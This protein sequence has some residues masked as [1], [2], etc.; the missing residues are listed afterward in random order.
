MII[1]TL[2]LIHSLIWQLIPSSLTG[3][4]LN[5]QKTH[6]AA[7]LYLLTISF[8]TL[9]FAVFLIVFRN[10]IGEFL[11]GDKTQDKEYKYDFN[12][13]HAA[14]ISVVGLYFI[15]SGFA[16]LAGNVVFWL[17]QSKFDK[18]MT[19]LPSTIVFI[20]GIGLFFGSR[21]IVGIWVSILARAKTELKSRED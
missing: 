6:L 7:L 12:N 4:E 16:E 5:D 9:G 11:L 19:F 10:K 13:Y 20:L 8:V 14:A 21:G 17:S 3:V 15:V 1:K 2:P 18:S